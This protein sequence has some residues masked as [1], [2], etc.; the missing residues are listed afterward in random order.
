MKIFNKKAQDIAGRKVIFYG[1]VFS[2][3]LIGFFFV[4]VL[5][6]PANA[7]EVSNI[8]SGL[9]DYF[10]IQ[11]FLNSPLC[12][13]LHDEDTRRTYPSVIDTEK[14]TQ[15]NIENCYNAKDTKVKAF[16]LTLKYGTE[17]KTI[18][19]KN[20]EGFLSKAQTEQIFVSVAGK[21]Q[22]ASLLIE[23]QNAK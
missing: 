16:R 5:I 11:R 18:N 14:F 1:L 6:V 4:I 3:L 8:R 12:F 10:I 17:S 13:A 19:T 22:T 15:E 21:K 7:S 2:F 9:D 23:T 20:W